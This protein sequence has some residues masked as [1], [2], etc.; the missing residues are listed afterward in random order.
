MRIRIVILS[1][2]LFGMCCA[3]SEKSHFDEPRPEITVV[4]GLSGAG[5]NGYND[6]I[7]AG[8]MDVNEANEVSLSMISP[9]S[10]DDARSVL[11]AWVNKEL[12]EVHALLVLAGNEYESLVQDI[13][14]PQNKSILIF[15]SEVGNLPN[16]VSSFMIHR[17]GVSYL[18][19]CMASEA[20]SASVIAAMR[21]EN[22]LGDAVKGFVEGFSVGGNNVEV[23]YLAED[24][25]GYGMPNEGYKIVNQLP[26]TS[27]IYP[28]A[29]GS[30]SGMYKATRE[31]EFNLNLIAGMDVDC[32]HYS[33]RVP[34]SVIFNIR[35]VV[36]SLL[37]EWISGNELQ[38][39]YSFDL[40]D[41]DIVYI[42][43]SESFFDNLIAW[44]DYYFDPDYWIQMC[45]R[46]KTEAIE[47]EESY[48]ED[49]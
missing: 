27:F 48:Y 18:A 25:S 42:S 4:L 21:T 43:F 34:F 5:D 7:L 2:I 38:A 20:K 32:S 12:S 19:G 44:D 3:C 28:L 35:K 23:I 47:K 15:E 45:D 24:E 10:M 8:I 26:Y 39:H 37:D 16:R 46:Y 31:M 30:N 17:Y 9:T 36:H 29:G 40:S 22:Y 49:K 14:L 41:D 33:T 11:S 1:I 6:E 13:T